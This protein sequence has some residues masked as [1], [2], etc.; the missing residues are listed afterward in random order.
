MTRTSYT[1]QDKMKPTETDRRAFLA[2]T[3]IGI[4]STLLIDQA[5]GGREQQASLVNTPQA[6]DQ[7]TGPMVG[8]VDASSARIWFRPGTNQLKDRSWTCRLSHGGSEVAKQTATTDADHDFTVVFDFDGLKPESVY[9]YRVHSAH[10]KPAPKAKQEFRTAPSASKPAKIVMGLGSC[11]PS[12][13]NHVWTRV[14][15]EG[16]ESFVL[17][18]DTPYI[19]SADLTV[20]RRK[21]REFLAQPEI[22][23]MIARMPIWGT[24][25]DHDFGKN[26]G[27]GDF[28]GKHVSRI[29]FTE[30]RANATFGHAENGMVQTDRFGSGRGIYTS[31]RRGP[32][33]VFLLDPRWFSR[34]AGSWADKSKPTCLG[35]QQWEWLRAGLKNST[36]TFKALATGMIWDDKKNREK[37]DWHTYRHEREEIF[38]FIKSQRISGCFLIGGDIHVS[39][40]LRY[41]DRVGYPL[42]QFIVSPLHGRTIP[43]L[44]VPHPNLIHHAVHPFVFLKLTVDTTV[45][46]A[47]LKGEWIDRD[48]KRVFDVAVTSDMLSPKT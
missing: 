39:R 28:P 18:G 38:K 37:D 45:K 26:D 31:F 20:A 13:P 17:L 48:G 2:G 9:S 32:L 46:P 7:P 42:W 16:C 1:D 41:D 43:S 21:H 30:Y 47:Q 29:A 14:I 22:S 40:A 34:T 35:K 12:D 4:A 15:Q 25:D 33:E 6:D 23:Q 5:D 44:D 36:A 10:S 24:W 3:S 8:H 19:D 11:A 27:H